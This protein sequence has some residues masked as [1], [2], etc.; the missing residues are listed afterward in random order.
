MADFPAVTPHGDLEPL[1]DDAWWVQGTFDM[2]PGLR[3]NRVMVV[4]RHEGE[5]TLINSI[6]L[7]DDGLAALRALGRIAHVVKI[8][9]HGADDPFYAETFGAR[10]WAQAG[11]QWKG[12]TAEGVLAEGEPTPIPWLEAFTFQHTVKPESALLDT[13]GAGL[14]IACDSLQAWSGPERCSVAARAVNTVV[15][16]TRHPVVI[17]PPWRRFMTP[18]GGTLLPDYERLLALPF[19]AFVG[20][21]GRPIATGAKALA[22]AA[23]RRTF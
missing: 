20:A 14:L 2:G 7:D 6:R 18:R 10:P 16:F 22:E 4:L 23:V 19:D 17:G 15:G 11:Q 1:R 21:H 5:L 9:T 3:I 13:R 8:G 12:L